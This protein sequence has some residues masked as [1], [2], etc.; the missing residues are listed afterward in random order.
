MVYLHL[1]E[2]FEEIEAVAVADVLRRAGVDIRMV[3]L[4][5]SKMVTGSHDITI[6]A[7][8]LF[9]EAD[10]E[11][12]E[13]ILLPG[14]MPGSKNLKEHAGLAEQIRIFLGQEK[15][16][17][18]ICAAPMVF[19]GLGILKGKKATIFPGM[20]QELIGATV[21]QDNV[22]VDGKVVTSRGPGTAL[23]FA[24][25]L[26]GLLKGP[27]IEDKLRRSMLAGA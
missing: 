6:N 19:G 17:G 23:N 27:E 21:L 1:A 9:E 7:D 16:L 24:L 25:T 26:T 4:T 18:A 3:S 11:A 10:Y 13:M 14:G 12:C 8:L 2:G 15:W 22:V 20:E 5:H